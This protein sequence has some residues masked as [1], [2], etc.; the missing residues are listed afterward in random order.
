MVCDEEATEDE[1]TTMN[2]HQKRLLFAY[3]IR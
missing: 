3:S 2:S 1:E